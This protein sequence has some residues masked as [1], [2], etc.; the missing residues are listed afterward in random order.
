MQGARILL[1]E[2]DAAIATVV[3]V[4]VESEGAQLDVATTLAQRNAL[5][6]ERRYDV[7]LSDVMLP[8]GNG[9]SDL[10][11]VA[12]QDDDAIPVIVLSAQNTLDTAVRAEAEGA[13]DYLPKPFD[14]DELIHGLRAALRAALRRRQHRRATEPRRAWPR[15]C[16]V[17]CGPCGRVA[18][19]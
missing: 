12:V 2:D 16:H 4:A 11:K 6:S 17:R 8:D 10:R 18:V 15:F 13:F 5:L 1:I 9:L 14:L 19:H 3:R 7:I